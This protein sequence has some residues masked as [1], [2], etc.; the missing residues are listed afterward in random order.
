MRV[1][2]RSLPLNQPG[3][4]LNFVYGNRRKPSRSPPSLH[5]V[6]SKMSI[7]LFAERGSPEWPDTAGGKHSRMAARK[8]C[9]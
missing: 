8:L 6:R 1:F 9:V 5:P 2:I 4:A 3:L 7:G